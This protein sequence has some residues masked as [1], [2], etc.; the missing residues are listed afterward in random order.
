LKVGERPLLRAYSV[1]SAKLRGPARILFDQ[2]AG[3]SVDL[4]LQHLKQ[5][6]E[7]IVSRKA[8]GTLVIDNLREGRNLYFDRQ[9]VPGWRRS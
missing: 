6:D 7:I 8:T 4:A 5:G 3:R 2:G 9:P 1:A